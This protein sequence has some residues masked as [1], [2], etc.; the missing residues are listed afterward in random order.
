MV[1]F[2]SKDASGHASLVGWGG[3]GLDY[4]FHWFCS[5]GPRGSV[6]RSE[7]LSLGVRA[8]VLLPKYCWSRDQGG[9][10]WH[11]QIA[12]C[13]QKINPGGKTLIATRV[14]PLREI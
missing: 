12:Q 2:F 4:G 9:K 5:T 14:I 13:L 3:V 8:Q 7:Y 11:C 10:M 6:K 1:V